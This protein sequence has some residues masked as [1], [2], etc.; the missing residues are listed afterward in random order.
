MITGA[1]LL[2]D[3]VLYV[4]VTSF[5]ELTGADPHY[6]CC[7][8][9]GSIVA[10]DAATGKRLWKAY[11]IPSEPRPVRRNEFGVQLWGPSGAGIW[12]SSMIDPRQ[13]MIYV[14][15]GDSY[16]DPPAETSDAFLAFHMDTG[17]LAWSR[18]MT[19]GDAYTIACNRAA[20]G[21]SNCPQANGPDLDFGSSPILVELANGH[22]LLVAGQKSGVVHAIDP[23]R[24]GEVVWQKRVGQGGK[25]GGV[26]WGAAADQQ[27]V[28]VAVSDVRYRLV[29]KDTPAAQP[30]LFGLSFL[31][32]PKS[33]GGIYAL[34]LETGEV[35][36]HTPHP[37]CAD[38]PGCSPA[39]SAAVTAIPGIAFSGGFD[40]HLRA[41]A[42]ATGKII[43]DV[44]TK[45][46]YRT[47]NGVAAQGGSIDGPG[48]VVADGMVYVNSGSAFVG[49][50]PGNVLL[51]FSPDGR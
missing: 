25:M 45:G 50:I 26:Q 46:D 6:P 35:V 4:P 47:V 40:G 39:Q 37:G 20:A 10:L 19:A 12:S 16:S 33:G 13:R 27:N 5:E 31:L 51:A 21:T 8:F 17:R 14:T 34:K 30:S 24:A 38:R 29:G 48:A 15:T 42:T 32:D 44:D 1:P 7:S 41:Y 3:G 22:R 23:D 18:Q 11:T 43:W 28:Y 2:A 49:T 36:W 9:R